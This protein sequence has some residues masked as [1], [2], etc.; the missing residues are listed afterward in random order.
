M[1]ANPYY[2]SRLVL[3]TAGQWKI[4]VLDGAGLNAQNLDIPAGSWYI[5]GP[6]SG[7]P[8]SESFLVDA[9]KVA[10]DSHTTLN[11]FT[12]AFDPVT[13]KWTISNAA[14]FRLNFDDASLGGAGL[15][16]R[17][18][19]GYTG[20]KT[21]ASSYTGDA[22]GQYVIFANSGVSHDTDWKAEKDKSTSIAEDGTPAHVGTLSTR[23]FRK[24]KHLHELTDGA[25]SP[26]A[27]PID[28]PG[29][30]IVPWTWFDFWEYHSRTGQPF[31][32]VTG[33][34]MANAH[35]YTMFLENTE[36]FDKEKTRSNSTLWWTMPLDVHM[37][38]GE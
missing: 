31:V 19:L 6:N 18:Y 32:D 3:E 11:A 24:W 10:L 30:T 13:G 36:T 35:N 25:S 15:P 17:D 1:T 28:D 29:G 8:D 22:V 14:A 7:S 16:L 33:G 23:R 21:G 26:L 20:N 27:S 38:V 34:D 5:D 2:L 12:T 4:R 37:Y 9:L